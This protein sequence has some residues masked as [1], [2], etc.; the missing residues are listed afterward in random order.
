MPAFAIASAG[1]GGAGGSRTLVQTRNRNAFYMLILL[2][3]F[4]IVTGTNTQDKTYSFYLIVKPGPP[5]DQPDVY[6]T[7]CSSRNQ[8]D[9]PAG[10]LV[11]SP[12]DKIKRNLLNS[13]RLQERSY[14]RLLLFA[15]N[16]NG[17]IYNVRHAYMSIHLAVET[18]QPLFRLVPDLATCTF[19]PKLPNFLYLNQVLACWMLGSGSLV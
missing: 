2:L 10:C 14:Y 5:Y 18:G 19:W 12:C 11:S 13:I 4:G 9:P 6:G 16:D 15:D 3:I 17:R 1:G 8:A 7:P